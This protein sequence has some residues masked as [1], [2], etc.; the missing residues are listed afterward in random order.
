M[1]HF[2]KRMDNSLA[3]VNQRRR[4]DLAEQVADALGVRIASGQFDGRSSLPTELEIQAEY[5]VSRTAVREATRLLSAKGMTETR[6]KT[7]TRIKPKRAWN[8]LDP[9]VLRWQVAAGPDRDFIENLFDMRSIFEPAAARLA[10]RH[11]E[12]GGLQKMEKALRDM[13]ALPLG[14]IEQVEA[15]LAF[16]QTILEESGNMLLRSLGSLIESALVSMFKINWEARSTNHAE[17]M[18]MH[19]AVYQAIKAKKPQNAEESMRIL[20]DHSKHDSLVAV[21]RYLS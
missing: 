4:A 2:G 10:A 19:S 17:R 1:F 9:D 14:S 20:L 16:H 13:T 15:D 7:G 21:A 11:A 18:D 3:G 12:N 5:G 8:L 6:P